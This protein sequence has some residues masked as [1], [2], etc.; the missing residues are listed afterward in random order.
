MPPTETFRLND[1]IYHKDTSCETSNVFIVIGV[2]RQYSSGTVIGTILA[3]NISTNQKKIIPTPYDYYK[4]DPDQF[5]EL[6][7]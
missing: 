7:I 4:L 3:K 5:P 6:F 2:S 1:Y